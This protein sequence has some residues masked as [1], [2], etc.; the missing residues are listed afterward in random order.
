MTCFVRSNILTHTSFQITVQ[1]MLHTKTDIF[2]VCMGLSKLKKTNQSQLPTSGG[3]SEEMKRNLIRFQNNLLFWVCVANCNNQINLPQ[4]ERMDTFSWN[5]VALNKC[6]VCSTKPIHQ[7]FETNL[8][9]SS[10]QLVVAITLRKI[11]LYI[12]CKSIVP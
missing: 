2:L 10:S 3:H 9:F 6:L 7:H 4:S 1:S 8:T 5:K 12:I 11:E